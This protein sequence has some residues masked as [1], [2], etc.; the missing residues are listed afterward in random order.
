MVTAMLSASTSSSGRAVSLTCATVAEPMAP[1]V[2]RTRLPF[3]VTPR[4][5]PSSSSRKCSPSVPPVNVSGT[6]MNSVATSA[7]PSVSVSRAVS[8][9]FP[10]AAVVSDDDSTSG[11]GSS[12][13]R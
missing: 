11:V 1:P 10:S 13:S 12:S 3:S 6:S 8:P 5:A 7:R 9:A 4:P 2:N